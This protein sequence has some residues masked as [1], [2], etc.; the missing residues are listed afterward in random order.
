MNRYKLWVG[1]LLLAGVI[2]VVTL[3]TVKKG[4]AIAPVR[5][6]ESELSVEPGATSLVGRFHSPMTE[7]PRDRADVRYEADKTAEAPLDTS[8]ASEVVMDAKASNVQAIEAWESLIDQL[9]K[10]EDL[11]AFGQTQHVKE[12]FDKLDK[13]DQMDGIARSLNLLQDNNFPVLCA[14]LFDKKEDPAVLDAIFSDALNRTE[15]IKTPIMKELR[16]DREHPMFF[17]AA[18]I[19]DIV[20]PEEGQVLQ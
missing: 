20:E 7:T 1:F 11:S 6:L 5:Q 10:Q 18:R 19:L 12:V 13:E 8:P 14:I 15:K 9:V 16:K 4:R 3:L 17:E 2:L